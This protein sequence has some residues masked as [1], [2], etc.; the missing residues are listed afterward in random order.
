LIDRI[1]GNPAARIVRV[2]L[3]IVHQS[4]EIDWASSKIDTSIMKTELSI[5]DTILSAAEQLAAKLGVSLNELYTKAVIDL[6]AR[7]RIPICG[8][9]SEP[10]WKHLSEDEITAKLNELY[11]HEPSRLDPVIAQLQAAAIGVEDW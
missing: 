2:Q 9:D 3:P 5:P 4:E 7:Y 1:G 10:E 11:D 8:L 6:L